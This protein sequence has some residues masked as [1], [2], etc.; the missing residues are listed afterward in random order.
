MSIT[1][2]SVFGSALGGITGV[3]VTAYKATRF[4]TPPVKGTA[5]PATHDGGPV[6]TSVTFGTEGGWQ[7]SV[8]TT[9]TY[10]VAAFFDDI[11]YWAFHPGGFGPEEGGLVFSV[12]AYGA[13]G[14]GSHVD[15]VEINEANAACHA[16]NGC[17]YWP[18]GTYVVNATL[19]AYDKTKWV[20]ESEAG[21]KIYFKTD[22]GATATGIIPQAGSQATTAPTFHQLTIV[23]PGSYALGVKNATMKGFK[24][25]SGSACYDVSVLNFEAGW[26]FAGNHQRLFHCNGN[27]NYY[28]GEWPTGTSSK[29]AHLLVGCDFTGNNFASFHITG[30]NA[31]ESST[32]IQTH[33]GFSPVGIVRTNK[34]TGAAA[35]STAILN[36]TFT[37]VSF[38]AIGNVAMLDLQTGVVPFVTAMSIRNPGHS[39]NNAYKITSAPLTTATLQQ[40]WAIVTPTTIGQTTATSTVTIYNTGLGFIPGSAGTFKAANGALDIYGLPNVKDFGTNGAAW[41]NASSSPVT[42]FT[43]TSTW[44]A[45]NGTGTTAIGDIVGLGLTGRTSRYAGNGPILGIAAN[46]ITGSSKM[47]IVRTTGQATVNNGPIA[48]VEGLSVTFTPTTPYKCSPLNSFPGQPAIGSARNSGTATSTAS[49]ILNIGIGWTLKTPVVTTVSGSTSK[50]TGSM[51][52]RAGNIKKAFIVVTS[53]FVSSGGVAYTFPVAF[54]HIPSITSNAVSG[55]TVTVSKTAASVTVASGLGAETTVVIEGY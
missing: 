3:V 43:R 13:K 20:G 5:P 11:Y 23:G 51:P 41:T 32:F 45:R 36:T 47:L 54:S 52:L 21:V 12:K 42:Y 49:V 19:T 2:S 9:A 27:Q 25:P 24:V 6:T 33:L 31:I 50:V 1:L 40:A 17:L 26:V 55:L 29:G 15:T 22:L 16:A 44:V 30:G 38:E 7:L 34:K 4:T 46:V 39:W 35:T 18:N 8:G 53:T 14:N 48:T 28:G 37:Q 10:W